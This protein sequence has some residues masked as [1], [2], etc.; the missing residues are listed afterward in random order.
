M[1]KILVVGKRRFDDRVIDGPVSAFEALVTGLGGIGKEHRVFHE[2]KRAKFF[3][4]LLLGWHLLS[5]WDH[6]NVHLTANYGIVVGIMRL[7]RKS[8][9]ITVHGYSKI[10]GVPHPYNSFMHALQVKHLFRNRIYVSS[11]IRDRVEHVEGLHGGIVIPNAIDVSRF[12]RSEDPTTKDVD[13]FS[14]CGYSET[15]GV[16]H[17]LAAAGQLN[18]DRVW[19]IAGHNYTKSKIPVVESQGR[20]SIQMYGPLTDVEIANLFSRARVYVQPSVYESFG[21]PVVEAMALGVPTVV[22]K[23]AGIAGFLTDQVN[24]LLVEPGDRDALLCAI[25][26]LLTDGALYKE[27]AQNASQKAKDF[28]PQRIATR[29]CEYISSISG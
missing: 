13:V 6:I 28:S 23:G 2:K 9:S 17:L 10:E 16:R 18:E 25:R 1:T 5:H 22:S 14:L 15:K 7:R 4:Y 29:Y 20:G 12:D 21:M 3:Q 8:V 11:G 24:S 19:V 27:I 26:R